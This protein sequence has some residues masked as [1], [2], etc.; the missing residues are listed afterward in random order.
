MARNSFQNISGLAAAQARKAAQWPPL[1]WLLLAIVLTILW[2]GGTC[3]EVSTSIA[4]MTNQPVTMTGFT[5]L[6]LFAQFFGGTIEAKMLAPFIFAWGVQGA[7]MIGSFG[8]EL[9]RYPRWRYYAASGLCIA[10]IVSN[11][12]GDWDSSKQYGFWGQAGFTS[13]LL[14]VTFGMG[15]FAIMAYRHAFSRMKQPPASTPQSG[16]Q[17]EA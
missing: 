9:P 1:V 16:A 4:W 3:T 11:S 6:L 5:P 13:V 12:C 7:G 10:L 2:L 15:L 14:F 17:P 8:V